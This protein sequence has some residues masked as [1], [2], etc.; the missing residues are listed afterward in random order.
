MNTSSWSKPGLEKNVSNTEDWAQWISNITSTVA[1]DTIAALGQDGVQ[2]MR[3]RVVQVA[4]GIALQGFLQGTKPNHIDEPPHPSSSPTPAISSSEISGDG[5]IVMQV[6][7]SLG[8]QPSFNTHDWYLLRFW[9]C[10]VAVLC[11]WVLAVSIHSWNRRCRRL[12]REG[13]SQHEAISM[14][15]VSCFIPVVVRLQNSSPLWIITD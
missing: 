12:R 9:S 8:L 11:G 15:W 4:S 7:N 14:G 1:N 2:K 5:D 6:V 13:H 3:D 10:F